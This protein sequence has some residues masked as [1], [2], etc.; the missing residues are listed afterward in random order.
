MPAALPT[1]W[2]IRGSLLVVADAKAWQKICATGQDLPEL[3]AVIHAQQGRPTI[4]ERLSIPAEQAEQDSV[5]ALQRKPV[6]VLSAWLQAGQRHTSALLPPKK[7]ELAGIVYTSGTT[8][9]PKGVMLTHDNVVS[10]CTR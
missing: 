5:K 6:I 3:Q 7:T 1:S 8:G 10:D 2:P 9:K 4:I